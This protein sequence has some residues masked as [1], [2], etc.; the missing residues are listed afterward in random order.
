MSWNSEVKN[1]DRFEFGSNW[2]NFLNNQIERTLY[3]AW[4]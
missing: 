3:L 4:R 2:A 1:G